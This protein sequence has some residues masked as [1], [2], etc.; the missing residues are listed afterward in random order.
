MALLFG[1]SALIREGP[2]RFLLLYAA[3]LVVVG[4]IGYARWRFKRLNDP[5]YE[6]RHDET[7]SIASVAYGHALLVAIALVAW[8]VT[9]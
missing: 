1:I 9:A 4:P 8:A 6:A 7:S 3:V 5:D 2:A